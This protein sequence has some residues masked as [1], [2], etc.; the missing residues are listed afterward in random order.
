M[1]I[2]QATSK[3][4]VKTIYDKKENCSKNY[5][6]KQNMVMELHIINAMVKFI[7]NKDTSNKQYMI[8]DIQNNLK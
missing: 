4:W 3:I 7:Y 1:Q 5:G 8:M 6:K 2:L